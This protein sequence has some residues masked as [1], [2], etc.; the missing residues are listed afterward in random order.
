VIFLYP[1]TFLHHPEIPDPRINARYTQA[2]ASNGRKS[3]DDAQARDSAPAEGGAIAV[4]RR[5]YFERPGP[6]ALHARVLRRRLPLQSPL[7]EHSV[8]GIRCRNAR[9][10]SY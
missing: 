6:D 10:T 4:D 9:S 7:P 3:E 1:V 2:S 8:Q 5:V